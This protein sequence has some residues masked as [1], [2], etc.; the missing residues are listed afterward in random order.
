M[1]LST[2]KENSIRGLRYEI[3]MSVSVEG[4]WWTIA[5]VYIPSCR[6]SFDVIDGLRKVFQPF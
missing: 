4:I 3:N 5:L 6:L 2:V 1:R